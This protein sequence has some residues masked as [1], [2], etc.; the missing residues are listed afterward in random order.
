M[1]RADFRVF[2]LC[3]MAVAPAGESICCSRSAAANESK[4]CEGGALIE[5]IPRR[6]IAG[7]S[8]FSV[9]QDIFCKI[10]QVLVDDKKHIRFGDWNGNDVSLSFCFT[11]SL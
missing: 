2:G 8:S 9:L 1:L 11:D 6:S 5:G 4:G 10:K 7:L 3:G